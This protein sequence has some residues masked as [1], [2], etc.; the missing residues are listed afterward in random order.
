MDK[1]QSS[2]ITSG[3]GLL[4]AEG[5]KILLLEDNTAVSEALEVLLSGYGF[6]VFPA[7]CVSKALSILEDQSL[8]LILSDVLMEGED[9]FDFHAQVKD[10]HDW[11]QLPFVF[12]SSLGDADN[13]RK[14]KSSGC[15]D[16]ITKPFHPDDL[17]A[18][19]VGKLASSSSRQKLSE[20]KSSYYRK[21][22]IQTLSHEFRT[23]LSAVSGGLELLKNSVE[24]QSEKSQKL[25]ASMERGSRRLTSLVNDFIV[26]Q[27]IEDGQ[28]EKFMLENSKKAQP[29]ALLRDA[30]SDLGMSSEVNV[31]NRLESKKS[32]DVCE[33]QIVDSLKRVLSNA[34]KF[35]KAERKISAWVEESS[36]GVISIAVRDFG[37]GMSEEELLMAREVFCQPGRDAKEQQGSGLG[38]S[39][40]GYYTELN[41]G[42]INLSCPDDGDTG[43]VA[44]LS[45]PVVS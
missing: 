6:S 3:E 45:F 40:A 5:A 43:L 10:H 2:S 42:L 32:I 25:F 37:P 38:L 35:N 17:L 13:V 24:I 16:Y 21:K 26:L 1:I 20:E 11:G 30:I 14:A 18:V 31:E 7:D 22:I 8:D 41:G 15:D 34:K 36:E 12:L 29:L 44:E 4:A 23:P 9:G 27:Q 33:R 19:I 28:A 39:I